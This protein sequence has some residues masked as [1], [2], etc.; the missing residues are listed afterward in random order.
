MSATINGTP[1]TQTA[2]I[3]VT[4]PSGGGGGDADA[5]GGGEQRDQREDLHHGQ[6][7]AGAQHADHGGGAGPHHQCGAQPKLSGGGMAAWTEVATATFDAVAT[8]HKRLTIFR[9]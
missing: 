9:A 3:Q 1:I 6:P 2:A 7:G 4:P 8:P 5:A